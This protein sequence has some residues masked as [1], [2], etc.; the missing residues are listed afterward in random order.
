MKGLKVVRRE[1]IQKSTREE[2][3]WKA[4]IDLDAVI[5][6][7]QKQEAYF[8]YLEYVELEWRKITPMA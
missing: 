8:T 4:T 6:E 7:S 5:V 2:G 3:P 1:M